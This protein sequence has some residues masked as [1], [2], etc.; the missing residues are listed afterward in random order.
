MY[1]LLQSETFQKRFFYYYHNSI[2]RAEIF[3]HEISIK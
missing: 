3:K 2:T 1:T